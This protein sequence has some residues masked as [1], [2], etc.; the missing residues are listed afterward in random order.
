MTK[1]SQNELMM[2]EVGD[3]LALLEVAHA[4]GLS[5][6]YEIRFAGRVRLRP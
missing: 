3:D 6:D 4:T 5:T 1:G 2:G